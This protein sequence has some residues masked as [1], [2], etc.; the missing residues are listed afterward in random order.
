MKFILLGGLLWVFVTTANVRA[1]QSSTSSDA[2]P[3]TSTQTA[4][5]LQTR[6]GEILQLEDTIR[7]SREQPKVMSIVPWQPP[8]E[9]EQLPSP[10]VQRIEQEFL[11]LDR[12][13]FRRRVQHFERVSEQK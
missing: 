9:K 12:Q 7:A 3:Q 13:E 6:P 1:Q 11:P 2:Q 5:S 8:L 4:L 10:F